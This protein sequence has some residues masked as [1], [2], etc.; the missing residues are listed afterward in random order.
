MDHSFKKLALDLCAP[1]TMRIM[2]MDAAKMRHHVPPHFA[3]IKCKR[4]FCKA[5]YCTIMGMLGIL[6]ITKGLSLTRLL[7][8][9]FTHFHIQFFFSF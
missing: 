7:N 2:H 1:N 3:H 4:L 6:G 8:V 9:D 5:E